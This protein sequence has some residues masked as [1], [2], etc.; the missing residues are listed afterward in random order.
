MS[1]CAASGLLGMWC[2]PVAGGVRLRLRSTRCLMRDLARSRARTSPLRRL[3]KRQGFIGKLVILRAPRARVTPPR[4]SR[5]T[6]AR[7]A[8]RQSPQTG[9]AAPV[10]ARRRPRPASRKDEPQA[11]CFPARRSLPPR[12]LAA[13]SRG[14]GH[15]AG[16]CA[17]R[18]TGVRWRATHSRK[19]AADERQEPCLT[20]GLLTRRMPAEVLSRVK[21]PED[22]GSRATAPRKHLVA[23]NVATQRLTALAQPRVPKAVHRRRFARPPHGWASTTA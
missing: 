14:Y 2:V 9:E 15:H 17:R 23:T 16:V 20:R 22:A 18:R 12:R 21:P 4:P 7:A 3:S 1:T 10:L 6:G 8:S 19:V 13:P 11:R 5:P